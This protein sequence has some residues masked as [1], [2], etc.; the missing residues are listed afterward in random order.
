M[1]TAEDGFRSAASVETL[2]HIIVNNLK[3]NKT[4]VKA[5]ESEREIHI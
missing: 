3:N 4:G 5:G 1:N 2:N